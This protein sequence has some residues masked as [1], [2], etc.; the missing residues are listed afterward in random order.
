[1]NTMQSHDAVHEA[2][3]GA[4]RARRTPAVPVVEKLLLPADEAAPFLGV[5]LRQFH[6][7]RD[8][9]PAPVMLGT[10]RV[11][12]RRADLTA[13]VNS[14]QSASAERAEPPQLRAGKLHKRQSGEPAGDTAGCH[15]ET[16]AERGVERMRTLPNPNC[17]AANT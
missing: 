15:A 4:V 5:S 1:M 2:L 16:Q 10:R 17:E 9:L 6:K 14:L 7:M 8:S 3:T 13:W 12:W 11:L